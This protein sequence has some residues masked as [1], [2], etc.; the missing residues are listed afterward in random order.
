MC[1]T[2]PHLSLRRAGVPQSLRGS[3]SGGVSGGLVPPLNLMSGHRCRLCPALPPRDLSLQ[4]A[5]V[6]TMR[7]AIMTCCKTSDNRKRRLP[8]KQMLPQPAS[9]A[10]PPAAHV[11]CPQ[12]P[13]LP[14]L[15][16][17]PPSL[18]LPSSQKYCNKKRLNQFATSLAQ[19]HSNLLIH[20]R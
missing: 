20:P 16:H 19:K 6:V 9:A 11:L 3:F 8:V 17:W 1:S 18:V 5:L 2:S 15:W 4:D 12:Q 10:Q 14:G 13:P 7:C